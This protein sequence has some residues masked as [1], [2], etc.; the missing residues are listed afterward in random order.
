MTRETHTY[1]IEITAD[2]NTHFWISTGSEQK[3]LGLGKNLEVNVTD[4]PDVYEVE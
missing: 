4:S 2:E 1:E 3:F